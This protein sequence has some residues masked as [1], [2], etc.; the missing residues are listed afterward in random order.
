MGGSKHQ[1]FS[2]QASQRR[3]R[4]GIVGLL[5]SDGRWQEDPRSIKGIILN[6]FDSIFK[7]THPSDFEASLNAIQPKVTSAM[8]ATL[9]VEFRA[10]EVWN[11][12]QQM[13]PI[14]F[15]GPTVCLQFSTKSTGM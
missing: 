5:D 13:H 6:Y 14:K 2:R 12:L 4:N 10:E 3:K 11:T 15:S 9:T 7:S 1:I 8:N